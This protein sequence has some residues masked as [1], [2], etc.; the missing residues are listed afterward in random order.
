MLSNP[1]N[2]Q[3]FCP[4]CLTGFYKRYDGVNK[5]EAHIL[6]CS[7][8]SPLRIEFPRQ[9]I[10][11]FEDYHKALPQP[12]TIYADFECINSN[13][14]SADKI[15]QTTGEKI[16]MHS[17]SGFCFA[18]VSPFFKTEFFSYCGKDAGI[19][20]LKKIFLEEKRLLNILANDVKMETLSSPQVKNFQLSQKCHICEEDFSSIDVKVKD[21][22]HITG[23]FFLLLS[24]LPIYFVFSFR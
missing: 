2:P 4:Y 22:C 5:L 24:C 23:I 13:V 16:S 10:S 12:F 20:F 21:H 1:N 11:K 15:F 9:K 7:D 8:V 18:I 17:V 19:R 3:V 6:L 14:D